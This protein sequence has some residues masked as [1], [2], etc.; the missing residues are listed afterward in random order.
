MEFPDTYYPAI[1]FTLA[2]ATGRE[3]LATQDSVI[4][5]T[6]QIGTPG[7][8]NGTSVILQWTCLMRSATLEYPIILVDDTV[9]LDGNSS[10]FTV[11]HIQA[12]NTPIYEDPTYNGPDQ[13]TF[14][15]ATLGGLAVAAQNMFASQVLQEGNSYGIQINGSLASQYI[16]YGWEPV[17]FFD[18]QD[19][20]AINWANPTFDII[21]A[22]NEI[23]FQ[24]ALVTT[25]IST[26]TII[27]ANYNGGQGYE[28]TGYTNY[29]EAA[30]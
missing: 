3:V 2:Y 16:D 22:L 11:D 25:N 1:N 8:C 21:N 24:T 15:F 26:Y 23:M 20:C 13:N 9:F 17:N 5:N 19:A 4:N 12:G 29:F 27:A 14:S 28:D 10:T 7:V 6:R 30:P 18:E